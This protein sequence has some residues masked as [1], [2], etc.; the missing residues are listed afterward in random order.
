VILTV[1]LKLAAR[2]CVAGS[3]RP[4]TD[5]QP[6]RAGVG[7]LVALG[8][9]HGAE[10]AVAG[11]GAPVRFVRTPGPRVGCQGRRVGASQPRRLGDWGSL[12]AAWL[13]TWLRAGVKLVGL[14]GMDGVC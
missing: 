10:L 5:V 8:G 14:G 4:A 11:R 13:G 7:W 12:A 1:R 2:G 3:S 9:G 6:N